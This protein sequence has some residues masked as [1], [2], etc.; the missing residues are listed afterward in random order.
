MESTTERIELI[1]KYYSIDKKSFADKAHMMPTT[2]DHILK[3]HKFAT[4]DHLKKINLAFPDVN[5]SW[6]LFGTGGIFG[7]SEVSKVIEEVFSK[8]S[9][10]RRIKELLTNI[11]ENPEI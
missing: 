1:M 6:L 9:N 11:L 8:E 2:L 10:V 7:N 4:L 5:H 3:G